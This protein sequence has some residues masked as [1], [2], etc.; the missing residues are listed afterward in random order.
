MKNRKSNRLKGYDYSKNNLYFV[1]SCV[2]NMNCC[3]GEVVNVGTGRDLSVHNPESNNPESNNPESNN[4]ESNNPEINAEMILNEFGIIANNQL[5]WL[6]K[7]YPYICLHSYIVMPN[8]I[9]VVIEIDSNLSK[10]VQGNSEPIEIVKIKS[11]SQIMG[12][13]KTTSSKLIHENGYVD[14]TWHRSLHDHIIRNEKSYFN[15]VNYIENNP[16]TWF[17]D[18]FYKTLD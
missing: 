9:H 6:E 3:F 17:K 10:T 4:P 13:Y 14:F 2:K 11:I 5:E 1:T 7:Q 18:K 16:N 12:A 15:I 8:H